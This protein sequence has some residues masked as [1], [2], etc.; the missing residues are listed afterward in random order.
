MLRAV[1]LRGRRTPP[2]YYVL[3]AG[4]GSASTRSTVYSISYRLL[5]VS[6]TSLLRSTV[7]V[8]V[9]GSS[10]SYCTSTVVLDETCLVVHR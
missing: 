8:V 1:W 2:A 10:T 9:V 7:T 6:T 3:R 4:G 5:P